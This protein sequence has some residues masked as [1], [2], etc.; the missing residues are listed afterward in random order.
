MSTI[1]K[2]ELSGYFNSAIAYIV[3]V[4]FL[5]LTG[6][7]TWFLWSSIPVIGV[8]TMRPAFDIIPYTFL[9]LIPAITM[10]SFSEEKKTGTIE[11]LLTRPITD[12]EIILGKFLSALALSIIAILPTLLYVASL[13]LWFGKIDAGAIF[14][15]YVGLILLSAIFV[16]IGIFC[17]SITENQ[18]VAFII[19]FLVILFFILIKFALVFLPAS[20]ASVF[21]YLSVNYHYASISRGVIDS[22]D[23]IYYL[24][25]I[26]IL[27]L[28]TR[29]SLESRKW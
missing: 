16:G 3:I 12:M 17:S 18:I 5:V 7:W 1:F 24:S 19:S 28:L 2:K 4:V 6:L 10:R 22:R 26:I 25:G 21:E 14:G 11:L 15:A 27:L 20:M 8:V 9:V 13:S 29:T 23:I